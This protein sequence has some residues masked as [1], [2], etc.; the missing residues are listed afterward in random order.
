MDRGG[1]DRLLGAGE[2]GANE[3][4]GVVVRAKGTPSGAHGEAPLEQVF[5]AGFAYFAQGAGVGRVLC[6]GNVERGGASG[7]GSGQPVHVV[8]FV[9]DAE[10]MEGGPRLAVEHEL[11]GT[12]S[13]PCV[14]GALA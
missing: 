3:A 14:G 8:V 6:V 13:A 11:W 1:S 5:G 9:E 7:E 2:E 10:F 4:D 12:L